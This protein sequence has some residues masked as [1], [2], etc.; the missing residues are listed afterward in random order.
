MRHDVPDGVVPSH[1]DL[2]VLNRRP[3]AALL[4]GDLVSDRRLL[5]APGPGEV[6]VRNI[7][8]SVDGDQLRM[9]CGCSGRARVAI[10]DPI[11]ATSVGLVVRSEDPA[12]PVG[13]QVAT[14]TGWQA[15]ATITVTPTEIADSRLGGPLEWISLL[16]RPGVLAYLGMHHVG[17]VRAGSTVL[18]SEGA[19]AMGAVAVQLASAAGA[20]VVAIVGGRYRSGHAVGRP[21]ATR[22]HG[23]SIPVVTPCPV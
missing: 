5:R 20:R 7:V 4:P 9:L 3:G 6:V 10:G 14:R 18:V 16:D 19:S 11:P 21:P 2:I 8:T 12:V 1:T 23:I 13:T 17:R 15:Y 22:G